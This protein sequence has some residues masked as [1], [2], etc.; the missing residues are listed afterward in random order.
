[1]IPERLDSFKFFFRSRDSPGFESGILP[2]MP[3]GVSP[4]IFL[5]TFS[6]IPSG[7]YLRIP[8]GAPPCIFIHN[9]SCGFQ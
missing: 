4:E 8:F 6:G 5:K 2:V 9:S 3:F 7:V 1:M